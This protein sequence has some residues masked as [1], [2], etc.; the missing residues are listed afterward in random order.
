MLH[1]KITNPLDTVLLLDADGCPLPNSY[2]ING[3]DL[4]SAIAL[5]VNTKAEMEEINNG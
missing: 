3:E 1:I 2:E 4:L 5:F